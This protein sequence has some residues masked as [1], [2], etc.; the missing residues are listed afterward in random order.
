MARLTILHLSDLH[1][2]AKNLFEVD[3]IVA[4]LVIDIKQRMIDENLRPDLVLFTG[5]LV[6]SGEIEENFD[7]AE[8]HLI[9]QVLQAVG[10][11]SARFFICPGNHDIARAIVRDE[12]V[13][14]K[15]L[16]VSTQNSEAITKFVE[17]H[18][19]D[20]TEHVYFSRLAKFASFSKK[21][22]S[23]LIRQ[24][25]FFSTYLLALPGLPSIGIAC[26][27]TA[28]RAT[29]EADDVDRGKLLAGERS[30]KE[31]LQDIK[32]A[33]LRLA[34]MHHPL[35][36]L[37]EYD[38]RDCKLVLQREFD[39]LFS[40]HLHHSNPEQIISPVGRLIVSES[41]SLYAGSKYHN[42]Y[43]FLTIDYSEKIAHFLHRRWEP[44][45]TC[46]EAA[47]NVASSGKYSVQLSSPEEISRY[48][49]IT[50]INRAI[51]PWLEAS[52]NE[53]ILSAQ[54][55][56]AAPKSLSEIYVEVTIR[57]RSQYD[58]NGGERDE[59]LYALDDIIKEPK[60][61]I[62]YGG[63]ESGKTIFSFNLCIQ[64]CLG[65][66]NTAL[67][68]IYIDCEQIT[69][70]SNII[71]RKLNDRVSL[72]RKNFDID[73]NLKAGNFLFVF[74]NFTPGSKRKVD[75][76]AKF[77][78]KNSANHFVMLADQDYK[79]A[80]G[81][82]QHTKLPFECKALYIHPLSRSAVKKLTRRWLS[83]CGIYSADTSE[84]VLKRL[85]QS[86]LPRTAYVVSMIAWTIERQN[87]PGLLNEAA[88]IE[89]FVD[90]LLN[91]ASLDDVERGAN[92][93]KTKEYFLGGLAYRMSNSQQFV[94]ERNELSKFALDFI[95]ARSWPD[96]ATKFLQALIDSGI[97]IE[98]GTQVSF[99]YR[100]L[101]EF[102]TAKHM[103]E[104][105][106][107]RESVL[108]E[109][110]YLGYM[111][112]IDLYTGLR[113]TDADI[114]QLLMDRLDKAIVPEIRDIDVIGFKDTTIKVFKMG[115]VP[116]IESLKKLAVTDEM[117]EEILDDNES[118]YLEHQKSNDLE[119]VEITPK[120]PEESRLEKDILTAI[121]RSFDALLLLSK[122][123]RNSEL[124]D[125]NDLKVRATRRVLIGWSKFIYKAIASFDEML[126]LPPDHE[127]REKYDSLDNNERQLVEYVLK[128]VMPVSV[129]YLIHDAL[130]TKKLQEILKQFLVDEN[131]VPLLT[132][133]LVIFLLLDLTYAE[134]RTNKGDAV[135][136]V[137]ELVR[138]N[139]S[140]YMLSLVAEKLISIYFRSN[141]GDENRG[142]IENVLAAIQ[143]DLNNVNAP[144]K[145]KGLFKS[146]YVEELRRRR[147]NALG[148]E[149]R[150]E[151]SGESGEP[152]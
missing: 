23:G 148:E 126:A 68:P 125:D 140:N 127:G 45:R 57:E 113:R 122:V 128:M 70:G 22:G 137:Q 21:L 13:I 46:F 40:G 51:L 118:S 52:A 31:A 58:R 88:L 28:W 152:K 75:M 1:I 83:P 3:E 119:R 97:L 33:E 89:R 90:S 106:Q 130:G 147:K 85:R 49:Q 7:L 151:D 111:R 143:I 84:I 93:F 138:T 109:E 20:G 124:V 11:S 24:T 121:Q 26:L 145:N 132:R 8:E 136:R 115:V 94:M 150:G 56:S 65:I 141:V 59:K 38:M 74:D 32:A 30:I 39:V 35:F 60:P 133:I 120:D 12:E 42:G 79:A 144:E 80:L 9:K 131:Q 6:N 91:K 107:F 76:I 61:L 146:M 43:C 87:N 110:A 101:R 117:I 62:I 149:K 139:N 102:F 98:S 55:N 142:S 34:L 86:N 69:A 47:L 77:I 10:L 14:E 73:A 135:Q 114:I 95:Q 82:T 105:P 48:A 2:E 67:V 44:T 81:V 41:G 64:T 116:R 108:S 25:P 17:K 19:K 100:C 54:T 5:D 129:S 18:L 29:G 16:K 123:V 66:G 104:D 36:Y 63:R 50:E 134:R 99:R 53:R 112:E 37:A 103:M 71:L 4:A 78:E 27:N 15:G 72:A 92:D 96:D